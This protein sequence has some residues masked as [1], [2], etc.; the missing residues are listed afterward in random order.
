MGILKLQFLYFIGFSLN[1]VTEHHAAMARLLS[2][3]LSFVAMSSAMELPWKYDWDRF[4]AAWFAG[5]GTN[6]E[7]AAQIAEIGRYSMAFML[8]REE[9]WYYFGSTGWLDKDWVWNAYY[10]L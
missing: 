1:C 2:L 8:A 10:D 5:N 6:W 7:D 3:F 4:A 9:G